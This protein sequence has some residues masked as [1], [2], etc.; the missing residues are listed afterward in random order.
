MA[1]LL[2]ARTLSEFFEQV[3]VIERDPLPDS[4]S[5]RQGVP[6]GRHVHALLARGAAALDE[7]FPGFLD[8][9]VD[10]GA[11]LF[12]GQDL[13]R[14]YYNVGGHTLV[15]TGSAPN[16]TV[17]AESRPFLEHHVRDRVRAIPNVTVRDGHDIAD[18]T[19]TQDHRRVT[20][21]RVV[22]R[23]SREESVLQ[24]DLV[25]DATGRGSRMPAWL[26][27]LGYGRPVE[28]HVVVHV[29]Y[30]SQ[31]LRMPSDALHEVAS[32]VGMVP[33][34]P[35]GMGV[36]GCENDT[37]LFTLMG[38]T[39]FEPPSERTEMLDWAKGL[40]PSHVLDALRTAEPIGEPIRHRFPSSQW[41]RYDKMRRFP[42]GLL[43]IGDAI[44]SFNPIYG[45]GM[46]VAALEALAL[47]DCL[48]RETR[49][50]APRFFRSARKPI[51]QAWQLA[52]G[53]DLSL[54]EV[55]GNGPLATR[56]LNRYVDRIMTAAE[57]DP[58]VLNHFTLVTSLVAP[59]TH[60]LHPAL[61]WRAA[62][63]NYKRPRH[64]ASTEYAVPAQPRDG[65]VA[66]AE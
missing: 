52:T 29:T 28:D 57:Y 61:L 3:T 17:Y 65:A 56:V 11:R 63:A 66:M 35:T 2:A 47:R 40:A 58:V 51:N 42:A 13:S 43:V 7:I 26:E 41:R 8:E 15:R 10:D 48:T 37:W 49:E 21:V 32:L 38:L 4:A 54:P 36:M 45:Q 60:L 44:C 6:Q 1:G 14:L 23:A 18:L 33:G 27:G 24:A 46:T 22:D 34:R 31:W 30:M 20:G 50:L 64:T 16:F 19:S 62:A 12:D 9:L 25:V 39:G 53:S 59:A 55:E 5:N